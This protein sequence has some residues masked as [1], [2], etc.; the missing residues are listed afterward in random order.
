MSPDPAI[1]SDGSGGYLT[2]WPN[3]GGNST[4]CSCGTGGAG[5]NMTYTLPSSAN[6][7]DLTNITVYGGWGDNGRNEQKYEV[8][9][10]TMANPSLFTSLGTFDFNPND[11]ANKPSATRTMLIPVSGA[12]AKNVVAVAINWNV[13]VAP[14]NDWEGYSEVVVQGTAS[15]LNPVLVQD[16]LPAYAETVVGDQVVF[17]ATFSNTPAAKFQWQFIDTNSVVHNLAGQTAQTLTLANVQTTNT[18]SY[19]LQA[20][21]TANSSAVAYSTA[22]SLVVNPVPAPINNVIITAAGQVGLGPISGVNASTDFTPTWAANTN[23][24]LVLGSVDGNLGTAGTVYAPVVNGGNFGLA[25]ANGDPQILSDG[26]TGDLT[27]DPGTGGGDGSSSPLDTCGVYST[28]AGANYAGISLTYTLNTASAINGF[29]LTNITVYGGWGD[30]T[31]NEQRYQVLYSTVGAPNTF[32]PMTGWVDYL[33]TDASGFQSATRTTL[34]PVAGVLAKNVYA[35]EINFNSQNPV[36]KNNYSGYSEIIVAGQVAPAR[37]ILTQD[38]SPAAAE[39]V[40][41]GTLTFAPAFINATSYQWLKNGTNLPGFTLP[42]LTLTKLKLADAA[43]NGGY[44]LM[45]INNLGTNVSSSCTV[46]VDPAPTPTNNVVTAFAYQSSSATGFGPTW[47]TSLLG[48]SLIAGQ[49]PPA[50]GSDSVANFI[51]GGDEAD[52]LPV[53]TDGS[54][55]TFTSD[56]THPAFAAGGYGAGNYVIYTLGS[57][58]NGYNVTNIQ[59]AG[60][61]NDFGRDSQVYTILYSTVGN[62]NMFIPLVSV[63]NDL[64]AGNGEAAVGPPSGVPTAVRGTF[65]PASGVLASNVYAIEVNFEFPHTV[66]NGYSGYSEISVFGSP[67]ATL[68]PAGP[69]ITGT[70]DTNNPSILTL[71]TPNLIAGELPSANGPGV[72]TDEGCNVTNLTDGILGYGASYG[73]SCGDDGTAVPWIVFT[74]TN[75]YWNLTNIVVY[76]MWNDYGRCGQWYN[77]SYSTTSNPALF[78]PLA[79]VGYNPFVPENGTHSAN[80]VEIAP[81]VSQSLLASNVAA[82]KFDFT[83]QLS[84]NYGWSGYTEIVLQGTNVPEAVVVPPTVPT[85]FTPP[86]ISGG[87]LILTGTGGKPPGHAYIWLSTTNLSAPII[88]T[89]NFTGNLDGAGAFSNAIP[90]VTTNREKFFR[91]MMPLP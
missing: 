31:Q 61:W 35:V 5:S 42:T 63:A 74:P 16:T 40:L 41:G 12:L 87:N 77:L 22:A 10:S 76:T 85:A 81:P 43:T 57:N 86:R 71:A 82:V 47:D 6:G 67:S 33:P 25:G 46:Y 78:L 28:V 4:Q 54:Y 56:G 48:E 15:L 37:P 3:V 20:V 11:P 7:Y 9:Y 21:S 17:T 72:F 89:T 91:F 36:P 2:Y 27:Y 34:T 65:T 69:V 44:S 59:I 55:G 62:P 8:L 24:D 39:D 49:N 75:G 60:G 53:L 84:L 1:L 38:I 88:W 14:K 18:G 52:G 79:S 66:A 30:S 83:P 26:I 32:I 90:V 58:P 73:A 50:G 29:D 70:H 23:G 45:A 80:Q 19:R 64:S 51:G 13:T 68:P